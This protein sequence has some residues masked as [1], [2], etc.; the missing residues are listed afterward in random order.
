MHGWVNATEVP[1]TP[2]PL[3]TDTLDLMMPGMKKYYGSG[4]PVNVFFRVEKI[5]DFGVHQAEAT[6]TGLNTLYL[7][8]WVV[9]APGIAEKASVLTLVDTQ[10][11][12]TALVDNMDIAIDIQK[13]KLSNVVVNFCQWGRLSPAVIKIKLDSAFAL[14]LPVV[15]HVLAKHPIPFPANIIPLF[16]MSNIVIDY[17]DDYIF[18]GMTPIFKGPSSA[19]FIQ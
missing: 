6:M 7:E 4:M 1:I 12:F 17:Y 16:T 10:F 13:I 14:G 5:S 11:S 15:N 19:L 3:N 8:F 2:N 18:V 9:T